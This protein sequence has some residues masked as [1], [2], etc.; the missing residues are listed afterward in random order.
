MNKQLGSYSSALNR[1]LTISDFFALMTDESTDIVI[2]KQLGLVARY[3]TETGVKTSFLLIQDIR[4]GT[5]ELYCCFFFIHCR[6]IKSI[7]VILH[8]CIG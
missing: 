5:A 8:I 7:N 3:M 1:F 2:R 6:Q 4:D